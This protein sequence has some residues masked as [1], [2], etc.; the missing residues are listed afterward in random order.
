MK[1]LTCH[2]MY[3]RNA[4]LGWKIRPQKVATVTIKNPSTQIYQK[5]GLDIYN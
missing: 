4:R 5:S 2:L 3:C 1:T